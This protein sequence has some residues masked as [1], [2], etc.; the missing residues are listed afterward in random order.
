[1][2]LKEAVFS[3][4]Y[5][6][7]FSLYR[8]KVCCVEL[9]ADVCRGLTFTLPRTHSRT[10]AQQNRKKDIL[11]KA[12]LDSLWRVMPRDLGIQMAWESEWVDDEVRRARALWI[13]RSSTR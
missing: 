9:F 11:F 4:I 8:I 1:M 12:K 7:L 5:P 10:H 6:R 13:P 2:A 3:R